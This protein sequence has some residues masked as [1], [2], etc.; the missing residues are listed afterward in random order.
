[1][2]NLRQETRDRLMGCI[3][4]PDKKI[5]L[6]P[7]LL[8]TKIV[9]S[10]EKRTV[11]IEKL[12]GSTKIQGTVLENITNIYD[13]FSYYLGLTGGALSGDLILKDG[14]VA[15]S[16]AMVDTKISTAGHLKRAMVD[17]LP[18]I[19]EADADTIY[20]IKDPKVMSGDAYQEYMTVGNGFAQIGDTTT[21]LSEYP[22]IG[23]PDS[24]ANGAIAAVDADGNIYPT[25][26]TVNN[27]LQTMDTKVD[28]IE[29][30]SLITDELVM[31]L[32]NMPTVTSIGKNLTLENG[33]LTA[34]DSYVLP[35]ADANTLGGV[36]TGIGITIARD[37]A[38][39]A[40]IVE[41]NGLTLS[42][43]GITINLATP[44][45]SGALSNEMYSK[46]V[47][48]QERSER[49]VVVG[50]VM[51]GAN[52]AAINDDRQIVVPIATN[53]IYGVVR[54]SNKV[55]GV[56]IDGDGLMI[57]NSV[58]TS[59]LQNDEDVELIFYGGKA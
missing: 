43:D 45:V 55:N 57:V 38:I 22:K 26:K 7:N 47:N 39:S 14:S 13:K 29:G 8:L 21:D 41:K 32:T 20:I 5:V 6:D 25:N 35:I 37:G 53:A 33:V 28:K 58:F 52:E 51:G 48:I 4:T 2:P 15:A 16:E 50:A 44:A 10:I 3:H 27:L 1:M 18:S 56:S 17:E 59:K 42:E 19:E 31:K 11:E 36:K 24:W 54:S 9:D 46:I 12:L 40:K 34:H 23:L 30:M 49:N